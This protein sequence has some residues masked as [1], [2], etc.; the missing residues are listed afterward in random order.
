MRLNARVRTSLVIGRLFSG[1]IGG[2]Q[3]KMRLWKELQM[4]SIQKIVDGIQSQ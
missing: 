1:L 4:G 2:R 3:F